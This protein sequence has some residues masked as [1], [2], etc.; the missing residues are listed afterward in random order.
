M[1]YVYDSLGLFD[2]LY[3]I[4]VNPFINIHSLQ[5][6]KTETERLKFLT[7]ISIQATI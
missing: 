5:A 7:N 3:K 6:N 2:I 4:F 1:Y